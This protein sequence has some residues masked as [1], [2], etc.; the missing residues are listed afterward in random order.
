MAG[1]L[2]GSGKSAW[3]RQFAPDVL[4]SDDIRAELTGDAGDQSANARVFA[5]LRERLTERLAGG[6]QVTW[7]DA[8]NLTRRERRPYILAARNAHAGVEAIW[9]DTPRKVCQARNMARG[10]QVPAHVIDA[11]AARS[12][13]P[14]EAEGFDS[15]QI[16]AMPAANVTGAVNKLTTAMPDSAK[17]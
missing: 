16:L 9:F 6:S 8:T 13:P 12:T 7:I 4:S 3:L 11:M 1:G 17:S 15:V 10:R 5:I 2:P 14:S